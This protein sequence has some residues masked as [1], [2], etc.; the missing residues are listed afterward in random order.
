MLYFPHVSK[1]IYI[2]IYIC[3][4]IHHFPPNF[5]N[6]Q[7]VM[8]PHSTVMSLWVAFKSLHSKLFCTQRQLDKVLVFST[9]FAE[10]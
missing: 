10:S 3:S 6:N 8:S 9:F 7:H 2:Y 4:Y 5:N 1:D